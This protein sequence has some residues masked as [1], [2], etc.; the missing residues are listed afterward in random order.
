MTSPAA[1]AA[2]PLLENIAWHALTGPHAAH[3]V[4]SGGARRYARG[5]SPI[6][7][8]AR[9]DEPDFAGLA[10]HCA[11]GEALYTEGW[12]GPLPDGWVLFAEAP[13][14][15]M[16]WHGALPS[17]ADATDGVQ[18]GPA[19]A[20]QALALTELTRPGP[21]GVRTL[22][23][24]RYAGVYDGEQLIAMAGERLAAGPFREVSG[25]CTHPDHQGRGHARRLMLGLIRRQLDRGETP[26]LNV[27]R[28]NAGARRLYEAMGFRT[29]R[30]ST[31]RVIALRAAG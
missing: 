27:L 30:E 1:D 9:P 8:F 3:A 23:L 10:G 5:Y 2:M 31:V 28:D 20:A 17:P 22:E 18:L 29:L 11:P 7:G 15:K 14:V 4:G 26:Y 13:L 12:T 6:V 24:G 16:V 21:F 19:D 25:V